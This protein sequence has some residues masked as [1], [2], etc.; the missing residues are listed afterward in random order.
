MKSFTVSAVFAD[1]AYIV[2]WQIQNIGSSYQCIINDDSNNVLVVLSDMDDKSL[3]TYL[4]ETN[5]RLLS[6]H[7]LDFK[8]I[9]AMQVKDTSNFLLKDS[10]NQIHA[11]ESEHGFPTELNLDGVKFKSSCSP[12]FKNINVGNQV[13]EVKDPETSLI[14]FNATLPLNYKAIKFLETDYASLL[15]ILIETD[16]ARFI[17]QSYK[18]GEL[19]D[20]WEKDESLNDIADFTFIEVT[21]KSIDTIADD[22]AAESNISNPLKAYSLRVSN[23][24]RRMMSLLQRN[25]YNPGKILTELL[26]LQPDDEMDESVTTELNLKF[27]FS[28]YLVVVTKYGT[29][30]ALDITKKGSIVWQFHLDMNNVLSIEYNDQTEELTVVA[31]DGTFNII[32]TDKALHP[33]L[34]TSK[35]LDGGSIELIK[36]VPDQDKYF[37]RFTNQEKRIISFEGQVVGSKDLGKTFVTDHTEHDVFGH[38]VKED[39]SVQDTWNVKMSSHEKIVAFAAREDYS[40]VNIGTVLGNRDVLYKYLYPNLAGFIVLNEKTQT[41]FINVID[42]V[43]GELLHTQAQKDKPDTQFPV[44]IIFGENWFIY[45]YFSTEPIPEQKLV[46]VELYESLT[47]NERISTP[48]TF[49]NSSKSLIKPAAISKAYFFPE[50][51]KTM[52]LSH[53]KYGITTQAL[54]LELES[55]QITY[56]PKVVLSARRKPESEM[57]DDDKKEF[58]ASPYVPAIPLN[59]HFIITH[60]R[61]LFTGANSRLASVATNLESTS[62]ICDIGHDIFCTRIA[63]SGQFDMMSPTFEKGKLLGTIVVLIALCFYLRPSVSTKK[64][65]TMWLVKD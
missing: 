21:D 65:K 39:G 33:V 13:L 16:D 47:A 62:I 50:I 17:F 42:T 4:N 58:M 44:N 56:I 20:E 57:T 64:L 40:P 54:L 27:G 52:S 15:K 32:S 30:S 63:P 26:S 12:N 23:N 60:Y 55:G 51:I 35:R 8:A 61:N 45:S 43:T 38:V 10:Y 7:L 6:R 41:L 14:L 49:M 31:Q 48:D 46:V 29:V 34:K 28:K 53:T 11:F 9:D 24:W 18:N 19:I 3:L 1:E 37:V 22:L 36:R 25:N 2:D 59:D 5:G